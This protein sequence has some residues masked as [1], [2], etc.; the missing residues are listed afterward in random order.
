MD[1]TG[2]LCFAASPVIALTVAFT[3]AAQK[4]GDAP[5]ILDASFEQGLE[6]W[7]NQGRGEFAV[8]DV[9]AHSGRLA[10]RI[11]VPAEAELQYQQLYHTWGLVSAGDQF[12]VT[13]WVRAEG[14]ADGT[15]AYAALQ[16][17]D[18]QAQRIGIEHS[19]LALGNGMNGWERLSIEGTA[20]QGTTQG[21]LDLILHAHGTAWFDDVQVVKTGSLDPWPDLGDAERQITVDAQQVVQPH[22]A[23][24][25]FHVFDHTFTTTPE[26]VDTVIAKRW[27]E[28]Q[29]S[30]ARM[31]DSPDWDRGT[32]DKVAAYILR[33]KGTGTEV[34]MTTWGPKDTQ[35]G[36]ERRAYAR[37]MVDNL[38]YLVREKGCTNIRWYCLTNELSLKQ[39]GS[40]AGDLPT[41][42]DYHQCLYDELQARGLDIGLLATD[43]SPISYWHTLEWA[44]ANMDAITAIYGG[45]HYLNDRPL[46]D[47]RFYPW[48][49]DRLTWAVGLAKG[50]GKDFILGEFGCKQDG[51]TVDGVKLD[52]CVYFDTPD[53][54][55]LAIQLCEAALA[56][57]N[58]GTYAM[59]NWTYADF[60]DEYNAHYIN[61]WG[62]FRWSGTDFSTRPHYYAYGLLTKYFRGPAT[63]FP[64]DGNDPYLRVAA[65]RNNT[66]E[67]YSIAVISRCATVAPFAVALK[68]LT[69]DR[70]FRK[71]VYD[72]KRPPMNAFG[73]LQPPVGKVRMDDGVLRDSIA[74]NT[75]VVYTTAYH[76]IRPS[77]VRGVRAEPNAAGGMTV[78]WDASPEPDICYYRVY[79]GE[80]ADFV[81]S[82]EN[83]LVSTIAT[84]HV[85][86]QGGP[87]RQYKV[88]AVDD[89]GNASE[90]R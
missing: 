22:F 84:E 30:F 15:G 77:P 49:L 7:Q 23:G 50:K 82:V 52:R 78:K 72:P 64:V 19:K 37:H 11:I 90:P 1:G 86:R 69:V 57:I 61:K 67:A 75:I 66:T 26:L 68:G 63:V 33:L 34:Y 48:F 59:G 18:D 65:V 60:P 6:G 83:Q 9:Q 74:P 80:R 73:D 54:P 81:P 24:V 41:F 70:P 21:R 47:E 71:Y 2:R 56:A 44:A 32:L 76:E 16:F 8:D 20:P 45:H 31:N 28:I 55:F 85:D 10:A 5:V 39:W 79:A 27:R 88:V 46:T 51:R 25:G 38:E 29:P 62:T 89:S 36:D 4:A 87:A 14:V 12:R 13:L 3:S 35:P 53:E 40:L 17:L 43:A 42:K 58:A